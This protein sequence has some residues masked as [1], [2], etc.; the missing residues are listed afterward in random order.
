MN[1]IRRFAPLVLLAIAI[2]AAAVLL[3]PA[4]SSTEFD[5]QDARFVLLLIGLAAGGYARA[6]GGRS[7]SSGYSRG[8]RWRCCSTPCG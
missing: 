4:Y 8:W 3:Y 1:Q 7:R 2:G 6:R 5:P